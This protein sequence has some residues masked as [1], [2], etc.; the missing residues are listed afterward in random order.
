MR[1]LLTRWE[2][3]FSSA[4]I[5]GAVMAV[6]LVVVGLVLMPIVVDQTTSTRSSPNIDYYSGAK[7]IVELIP[8]LFAVGV[9]GLAGGVAFL[10]M[11]GKK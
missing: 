10:S 7:A 2:P 8:L 6:V 5:L 1:T 9:L 4:H 3:G 11:R